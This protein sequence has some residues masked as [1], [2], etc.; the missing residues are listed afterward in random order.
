MVYIFILTTEKSS[1]VISLERKNRNL[2]VEINL[3]KSELAESKKEVSKL[4]LEL[5]LLEDAPEI[6]E[7]I[8][9]DNDGSI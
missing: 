4:R 9:F 7:I 8:R 5:Q 2:T 3:I 1:K 6:I